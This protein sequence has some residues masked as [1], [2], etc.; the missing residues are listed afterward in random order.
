[1]TASPLPSGPITDRERLGWQR[2]AVRVL[3]ELLERAQTNGL[4]VV[5]WSVSHAGAAL[6]AR[7]L[8][9]PPAQ[10]HAD[11]DAWC[12]ALGASRWPERTSG[13]IAHL[14]AVAKNYDGLVDVAVLADLDDQQEAPGRSQSEL[15]GLGGEAP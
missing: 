11:F 5:A 9:H 14:Y 6:V 1:V 15:T 10:R 13:S 2:R 12:S 3:A 8:A 7:C 4:P